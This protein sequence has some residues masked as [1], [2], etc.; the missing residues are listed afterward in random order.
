VLATYSERLATGL[1][2][3]VLTVLARRIYDDDM[4]AFEFTTELGPD[5][6]VAIPHEIAAQ[7]PKSGKARIIV[8][9][10]NESGDLSWQLGAYE[11]FMRDDAP[12]D[13]VYD[14]Y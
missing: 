3:G 11:Q 5:P 13:A 2:V 7:L 4:H 10:G 14:D 12:E 9:I 6:I 8:L 1:R